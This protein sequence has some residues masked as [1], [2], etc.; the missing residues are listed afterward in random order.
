MDSIGVRPAIMERHSASDIWPGSVLRIKHFEQVGNGFDHSL[1]PF[2]A[3]TV[4]NVGMA[5]TKKIYFNP[6]P[7]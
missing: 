5:G 1:S 6:N 7:W 3:K 4:G 2:V